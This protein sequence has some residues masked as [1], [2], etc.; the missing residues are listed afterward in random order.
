MIVAFLAQWIWFA[1]LFQ[2]IEIISPDQL[3]GMDKFQSPA[4]M[5]IKLLYYSQIVSAKVGFG[6]IS[7]AKWPA[8]VL[9]TIQI[10]HSSMMLII[11]FRGVSFV[12]KQ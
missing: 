7:P 9:T 11:W 1:G 6:D 2:S 10:I 3:D 12:I 8:R 5:V 4:Q